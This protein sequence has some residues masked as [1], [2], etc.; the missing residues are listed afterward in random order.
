MTQCTTMLRG[1][2]QLVLWYSLL[3]PPP[4]SVRDPACI[5]D[6][7]S[8]RWNTVMVL[9]RYVYLCCSVDFHVVAPYGFRVYNAP[10]FICWFRRCANRLLA[11][12]TPL[13]SS[14]L[15]Y[16]VLK[17][18]PLRFHAR[19]RIR[20]EQTLAYVF[21]LWHI[22]LRLHVCFCCVRCSY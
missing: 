11:Y 13:L 14:L 2:V 5:W 16:L 3:D 18:M 22:L 19:G 10:G 1:D 12:F 17:N 20:G 4:A 8:I 6:P 7:A 15:F 9:R 21:V